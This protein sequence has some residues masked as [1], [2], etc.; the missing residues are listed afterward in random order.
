MLGTILGRLRCSNSNVKQAC[1]ITIT[2][3]VHLATKLL[4]RIVFTQASLYNWMFILIGF[5]YCLTH[6]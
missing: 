3:I 5:V 1:T 4:I 6:H 2:S